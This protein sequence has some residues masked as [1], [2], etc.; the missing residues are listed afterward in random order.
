MLKKGKNEPKESF[1][2]QQQ[3][4]SIKKRNHKRKINNEKKE[5]IKLKSKKKI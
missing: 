4:K 5:I 2:I 3:N 1:L